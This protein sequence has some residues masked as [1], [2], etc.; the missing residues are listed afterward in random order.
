MDPFLTRLTGLG[1]EAARYILVGIL[2]TA[3]YLGSM[4]AF[5]SYKPSMGT[6]W[7]VSCSF[8]IAVTFN[9]L[10]HRR[11]TFSSSSN[12]WR[13]SIAKYLLA[14]VGN[15]GAQLVIISALH[16][17]LSWDLM[18]SAILASGFSVVGGYLT[19]SLWVFRKDST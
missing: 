12:S 14:S 4:M 6:I 16:D 19:S 18:F 10:A 11:F 5:E 8:S 17:F 3:I 2:T 7:V 1:V 9:F 13:G 15:Y